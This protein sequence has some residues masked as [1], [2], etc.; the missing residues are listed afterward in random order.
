[1]LENTPLD[2]GIGEPEDARPAGEWLE[3]YWRQTQPWAMAAAWLCWVYAILQLYASVRSWS[4]YGDYALAFESMIYIV[5]ALIQVAPLALAG[6]F[7]YQFATQLH[8]ALNMADQTALESAFRQLWRAFLLVVIAAG[9][10]IL[11]WVSQVILLFRYYFI[12]TF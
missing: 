5:G 4:I 6:Y 12:G 8:L 9:Y 2:A 11:G 1:M 7:L 10:W 3:G